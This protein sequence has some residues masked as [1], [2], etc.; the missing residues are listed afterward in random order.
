[1]ADSPIECQRSQT[2]HRQKLS[3]IWTSY[4]VPWSRGFA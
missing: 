3:S 1:M 4:Q 2:D